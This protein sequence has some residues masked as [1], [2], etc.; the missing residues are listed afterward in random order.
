MEVSGVKELVAPYVQ[1]SRID[2]DALM[3]DIKAIKS[4]VLMDIRLKQKLEEDA[5]EEEALIWML[6]Y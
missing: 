2:W 6:S 1:Q 5:E 4:L 3:K